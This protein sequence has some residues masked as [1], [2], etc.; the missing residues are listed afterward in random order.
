M[1]SKALPSTRN[2]SSAHRRMALIS[3]PS[4][5]L[6]PGQPESQGVEG[7]LTVPSASDELWTAL[8]AMQ[9]HRC[10]VPGVHTAGVHRLLLNPALPHVH[11]SSPARPVGGECCP[12][13]VLPFWT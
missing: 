13:A 10:Q 5:P 6:S 2:D 1:A 9:V 4:L 3:F 7:M 8:H 12:I 11:T